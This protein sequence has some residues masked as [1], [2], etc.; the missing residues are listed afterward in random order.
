MKSKCFKKIIREFSH[1]GFVKIEF[2]NKCQ[3]IIFFIFIQIFDVHLINASCVTDYSFRDSMGSFIDDEEMCR[4]EYK[5]RWGYEYIEHEEKT[6]RSEQKINNPKKNRQKNELKLDYS[7]LSGSY[8]L[9]GE[10]SIMSISF[11]KTLVRRWIP[12][13]APK[14]VINIKYYPT[15]TNSVGQTCKLPPQEF[16]LYLK[17]NK[18]E[19]NEFY[20]L[21]DKKG[22]KL[23]EYTC[24][25]PTQCQIEGKGNCSKHEE[26][27]ISL[28]SFEPDCTKA[29]T[30]FNLSTHKIS[31]EVTTQV[32]VSTNEGGE[33]C[34]SRKPY[35]G[36]LAIVQVVL[37]KIKM[38]HSSFMAAAEGLRFANSMKVKR[39]VASV[40]NCSKRDIKQSKQ[41]KPHNGSI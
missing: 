25:T 37:D 31:R 39:E 33:K 24:K 14:R 8:F 4:E 35:Q 36:Y 15:E 3:I 10:D 23:G 29:I 2:N 7:N 41:A 18:V 11:D 5:Q 17:A 19:P 21:T 30:S 1:G 12:F 6:F 27:I 22:N 16:S 38:L 20:N 40:P 32:K 28:V 13:L 26:C 34:L 9:Q